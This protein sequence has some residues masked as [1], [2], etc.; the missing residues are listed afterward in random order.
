AF[1]SHEA[2]DRFVSRLIAEAP[3]PARLKAVRVSLV[4]FEPRPQFEIAASERCTERRVSIPADI[5]TCPECVAEIFD[6]GDR[7]FGYPFTN[8]TNCGPRFTIALDVPY[9]RGA[10]TMAPFAMCPGC[11]REYEDP[12]NRRFHAE[13]N[14]CPKCGPR[15]RLL[16]ATGVELASRDPI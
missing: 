14:A 9:D 3:E 5:A 2:L 15:L 4:K 7:R 6:P 10:T 8:C 11:R 1:G 13:P 16:G 12:A